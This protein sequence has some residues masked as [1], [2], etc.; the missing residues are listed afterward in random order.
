MRGGVGFGAGATVGV[1]VVAAADVG[2]GAGAGADVV[3]MVSALY[4]WCRRYNVYSGTY[5]KRRSTAKLAAVAPATP[6]RV[7]FPS[8]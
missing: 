5:P 7:F 2:A 3:F 4:C 8:S 6:E 1:V